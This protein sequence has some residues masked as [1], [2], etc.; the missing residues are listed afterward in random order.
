M[1]REISIQGVT[2]YTG[3]VCVIHG[4][5]E[6]ISHRRVETIGHYQLRDV[7]S[8][9]KT[10]EIKKNKLINIAKEKYQI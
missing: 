5:D 7:E 6:P 4:I 8:G 3:A 2:S 9:I 1:K 10:D